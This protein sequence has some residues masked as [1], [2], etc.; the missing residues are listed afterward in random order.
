M[1][2]WAKIFLICCIFLVPTLLVIAMHFETIRSLSAFCGAIAGALTGICITII[3]D[4][5]CN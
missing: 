3:V 1:K 2:K 5:Y 4:K